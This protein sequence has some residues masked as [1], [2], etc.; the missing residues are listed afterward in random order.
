MCFWF[1][2]FPAFSLLSSSTRFDCIYIYIYIDISVYIYH[3]QVDP[4]AFLERA[5]ARARNCK[6]SGSVSVLA[7]L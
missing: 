7:G 6:L 4:F 1:P 2:R 3:I 5:H